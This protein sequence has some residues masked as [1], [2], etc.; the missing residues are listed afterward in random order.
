MIQTYFDFTKEGAMSFYNE[1]LREH[2]KS[3][4][5]HLIDSTQN[6]HYIP[7]E[8]AFKYDWLKSP[9]HR[10][11]AE[12]YSPM[13]FDDIVEKQNDCVRKQFDNLEDT[14]QILVTQH[15]IRHKNYEK[16]DGK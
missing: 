6:P 5:L 7:E 15:G 3:V 4:Y 10:V 2:V 16:N 14:L 13:V 9:N 8:N 11:F 12:K 1:L